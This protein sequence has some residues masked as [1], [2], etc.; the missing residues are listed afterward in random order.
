MLACVC[1]SPCRPTPDAVVHVGDRLAVLLSGQQNWTQRGARARD[2][3]AH[4]P[5]THTTHSGQVVNAS[6]SQQSSARQR[7]STEKLRTV[8][9]RS[10]ERRRRVWENVQHVMGA[11]MCRVL[12]FLV[13]GFA[14]TGDIN[15][16]NNKND[17]IIAA[18]PYHSRTAVVAS[19]VV[20]RAVEDRRL[21][22]NKQSFWCMCS[23]KLIMTCRTLY[24][25]HPMLHE[26]LGTRHS[27]HSCWMATLAQSRDI[28]SCAYVAAFN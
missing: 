28:R 5:H 22:P 27:A 10:D 24:D 6:R 12:C 17:E 23:I 3:A 16:D 7:S 20:C 25:I 19:A 1:V 2:V 9:G 8:I 21:I 4:T 26:T 11:H 18:R 14:G 13:C 15:D